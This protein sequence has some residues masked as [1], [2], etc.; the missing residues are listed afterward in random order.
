[1]RTT[2][3]NNNNYDNMKIIK[4]FSIIS[5]IIESFEQNTLATNL[6]VIFDKIRINLS[7]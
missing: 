2:F 7:H 6:A 5:K 4:K 3:E 1:M